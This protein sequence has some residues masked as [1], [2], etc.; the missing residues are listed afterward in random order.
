MAVVTDP[1]FKLS[2]KIEG[3]VF[4]KM[5]G[6][7]FVSA[8]PSHYTKS[9]SKEAVEMRNNFSAAVKFSGEVNS[10][11]ELK[12]IW[13]N[14][15]VPGSSSYN[16]IVKSTRDA[17][18]GGKIT[19]KAKITP[20]GLP[21][22]LTGLK[23]EKD[24]IRIDF[25]FNKK[26]LR[27]PYL[28]FLFFFFNKNSIYNQVEEISIAG[29]KKVNTAYIKLNHAIKKALNE[30]KNTLIFCALA[31]KPVRDKIYWTSTAV[32]QL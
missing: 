32:V 5:N 29:G 18:E 11:P 16:K 31:G 7:I 27:P 10:V 15:G 20:D 17:A 6:K 4:R 3:L 30:K 8:A 12:E 28:L 2:G 21:L 14:A 1:K 24:I 25:S 22:G 19:G 23:R 13:K 26:K 9:M